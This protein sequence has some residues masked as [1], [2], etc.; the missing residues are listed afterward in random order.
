MD[1]GDL[2]AGDLD[3]GAIDAGDAGCTADA[4]EAGF[5]DGGTPPCVG[6]APALPACPDVT[7]ALDFTLTMTSTTPS[8]GVTA[9]VRG[10]HYLDATGGL[11]E[12]RTRE[13]MSA[14]AATD[15]LRIWRAASPGSQLI[16]T[17]AP[18]T[19]HP[20]T[21]APKARKDTVAIAGAL[22][23]L[24]T[25]PSY[26]MEMLPCLDADDTV[27][28]LH[29]RGRFTDT[30]V[31][32][33]VGTEACR[34]MMWGDESLTLC[35]PADCDARRTLYPYWIHGPSGISVD[36][37]DPAPATHADVVVVEP[38]AC[39]MPVMML[40]LCDHPDL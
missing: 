28:C 11:T 1:A 3:A 25:F 27:A 29:A 6:P 22:N 13:A 21:L 32:E 24:A 37:A 34:V 35:V 26:A 23:S 5:E 33:M 14:P 18:A 40:E 36:F 39:T 19:P 2:D 12:Q 31:T 20:M 15:L 16:Y 7:P 8:G 30:G 9:S 17:I 4:G 38:S 10:R